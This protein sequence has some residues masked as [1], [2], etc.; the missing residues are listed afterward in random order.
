[1]E[2]DFAAGVQPL[3]PPRQGLAVTDRI[4]FQV[5]IAGEPAGEVVLGLWGDAA[6]TPVDTLVQLAKGTLA[7]TPGDAPASLERSV[8]VRCT[9]DKEVVLGQLKKQGGQTMLVQGQTRPKVVPVAAPTWNGGDTNGVSH[10]AAGLV[11]VRKG[12]GSFEFSLT[13]RPA[14]SLDKEN[15]IVGQIL[16]NMEL[17]ER[18]N[19]LP[20]NV[21]RG[22]LMLHQSLRDVCPMLSHWTWPASTPSLMTCAF[23]IARVGGVCASRCSAP[24]MHFP[25][26]ELQL[27]AYGHGSS[28]EGSCALGAHRYALPARR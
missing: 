25:S 22:A 13:T 11:S 5:S 19:T 7:P 2:K 1:M 12:G 26:T 17:L 6:P 21:R 27:C 20:T 23:R 18:L 4:R 8:A 24:C 15:L 14:P 9:K 10:D 16:E 28:G 3:P